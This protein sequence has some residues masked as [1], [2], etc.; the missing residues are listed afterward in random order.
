MSTQGVMASRARTPAGRTFDHSFAVLKAMSN[1]MT[2]GTKLAIDD[3][4]ATFR[5][6]R[7]A[8][9]R[10]EWVREVEVQIRT[11]TVWL[12]WVSVFIVTLV[13]A[14]LQ[15]VLAFAASA[16]PEIIGKQRPTI[17]LADLAGLET[18]DEVR[19]ELLDKW[20]RD[21]VSDGG[22]KRWCE[23]LNGMLGT[24]VA[25]DDISLLE[26]LWGVRH[27]TVHSSGFATRE[28]IRNHPGYDATLD[29][30]VE[31]TEDRM[32]RWLSVIQSF[33]DEIDR[34]VLGYVGSLANIASGGPS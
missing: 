23:R 6:E 8:V 34:R 18:A 24:G 17:G 1:R 15:D 20:A 19:R 25:T 13:E 11:D 16:R 12:Q 22:P 28:F 10:E 27:V 32:Q 9:T 30:A 21:F 29:S 31:V 33:M 5:G 14:Y 3:L 4:K 7:R 2:G 26:E